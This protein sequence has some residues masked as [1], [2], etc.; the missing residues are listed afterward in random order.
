MLLFSKGNLLTAAKRYDEAIKVFNHRS[1]G[2]NTNWML[3]YAY[4]ASGQTKKAR[5]ILN[6]Q[7]EKNKTTFVPPYMIA[8]LYMGIGDVDNALNWLEKDYEVGGQGLFFWAL[9]RDFKF[10]PLKKEPRFIALLNKINS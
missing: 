7:L 3:G 6:Y 10:E 5:E 9:K 4:G 1:V 8:T 2:F